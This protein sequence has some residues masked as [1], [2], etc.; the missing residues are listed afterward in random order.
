MCL[1]FCC[2]FEPGL[3][4]RLLKQIFFFFFGSVFCGSWDLFLTR[5]GTEALSS[6][7]AVSLPLNCWG[8]SGGVVLAELGEDLYL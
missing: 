8:F 5:D 2:L 3:Y 6:E 4:L 1:D 7:S